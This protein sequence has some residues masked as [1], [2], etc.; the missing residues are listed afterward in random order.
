MS[1]KQEA[2]HAIAGS[3]PELSQGYVV[4]TFVGTR[5]YIRLGRVYIDTCRKID[6]SLWL[7]VFEAS[8]TTLFQLVC[9]RQG[10]M[11]GICT[12]L[13]RFMYYLRRDTLRT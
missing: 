3:S 1:C 6:G 10:R 9:I 8:L 11:P 4:E 13:S 7:S 12:F 5:C 2:Y